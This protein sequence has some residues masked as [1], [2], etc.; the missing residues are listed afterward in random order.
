[1]RVDPEVGLFQAQIR[2][3]LAQPDI[4]REVA[5]RGIDALGGLSQAETRDN[6]CRQQS[7]EGIGEARIADDGGGA[8]LVAI[9]HANPKGMAL[10]YEN[11]ADF[12]TGEH[13]PARSL[14][15]GLD[16]GGDP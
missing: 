13:S 1:M 14:D 6:L 4:Q 11:S 15:E 2:S 5:R 9:G 16:R 7:K 12:S 3:G 8:E 10:F